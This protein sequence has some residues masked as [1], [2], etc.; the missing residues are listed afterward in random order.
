MSQ[1]PIGVVGA[2]FIA[3]VLPARKTLRLRDYDYTKP[4]AYFVAICC[5]GRHC[6]LGKICD[7]DVVPSEAGHLVLEHW[8]RIAERFSSVQ[9]DAFVLMPNH[10]HGILFLKE[11][12]AMNR[13]PTLGE[14]IRSFKAMTTRAANGLLSSPFWQR[15]Y[16]ERIV[17]DNDELSRIREYIGNNPRQWSLDEE[18]PDRALN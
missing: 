6:L 10:V 13:A 17:R 18:N 5:A 8:L 1:S 7:D 11:A 15:G 4:G 2:R 3:P 16:H 14:V 12:G 9:L